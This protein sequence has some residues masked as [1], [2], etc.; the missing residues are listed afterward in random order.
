MSLARPEKRKVNEDDV[1]IKVLSRYFRQ[2][3]MYNIRARSLSKISSSCQSLR[4]Q[5]KDDVAILH[6]INT[7]I[8]FGTFREFSPCLLWKILESCAPRDHVSI[9]NSKALYILFLQI[10]IQL[11]EDF[12]T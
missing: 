2:L 5:Q 7:V 8:S 10:F 12:G 4:A 6:F 11:M 3:T 1:C 9:K